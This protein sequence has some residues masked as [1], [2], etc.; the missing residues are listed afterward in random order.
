[1][2]FIAWFTGKMMKVSLACL[3]WDPWFLVA[4]YLLELT[5]DILTPLRLPVS[6]LCDGPKSFSGTAD[7]SHQQQYRVFQPK[8]LQCPDR[9]YSRNNM[10]RRNSKFRSR[11]TIATVLRFW[12]QL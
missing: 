1:M 6:D 2:Q 12:W 4:I 11:R 3:A 10:E 7:F 9:E 8:D 5:L